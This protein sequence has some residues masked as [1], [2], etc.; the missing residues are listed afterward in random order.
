[1]T[2]ILSSFWHQM[3]RNQE[4]LSL[5]MTSDIRLAMQVHQVKT[6]MIY[7]DS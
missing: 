3:A 7:D 2:M 4:S 1:M 5:Y 6:W